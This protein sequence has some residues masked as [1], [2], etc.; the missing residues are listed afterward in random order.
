MATARQKRNT[1]T[2][3]QRHS[4]FLEH[5]AKDGN[6]S[7]AC[8]MA[9]YNRVRAYKLRNEE[10]DKGRAFKAKW[11]AALDLGIEAH[12]DE[13]TRRAFLG[14]SK[15]VWY[16]GVICGEEVVYSDTLAMFLMKAHRPDKFKERSV[17][18]QQITLEDVK[19][20]LA[21][22]LGIAAIG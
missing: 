12:E 19:G 3:E 6:V 14:H 1:P 21:R 9:K 5:L 17:V 20:E 7:A 15:P 10:S 4:V 16:K 11:E 8:E 13:I 22:K 2:L 18:E